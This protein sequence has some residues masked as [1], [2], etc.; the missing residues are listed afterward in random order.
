MRLLR[1]LLIKLSILAILTIIIHYY[2]IIVNPWTI[3]DVQIPNDINKKE[4]LSTTVN[5]TYNV[6]CIFTKISAN[7]PMI[8]KFLIFIESLIKESSVKI[9]FHLIV[10][11]G[12]QLIAKNLIDTVLTKKNITLKVLK[13]IHE[14]HLNDTKH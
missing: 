12:S 13:N 6:W 11:E 1:I 3:R 14:M 9:A 10:D 2:E 8:K 5:L 7:S 4:I